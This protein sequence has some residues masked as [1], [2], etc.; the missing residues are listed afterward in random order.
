MA[1]DSCECGCEESLDLHDG[2]FC[3]ECGLELS[4]PGLDPGFLV[5]EPLVKRPGSSLG[6]KGPSPR[7]GSFFRVWPHRDSKGSRRSFIDDLAY[8]A[9]DSGE[10]PRIVADVVTLMRDVDERHPLGMRRRSLKGANGLDRGAARDYRLRLFVSAALHVLNDDGLENRAPMI[11]QEWGISYHDSVWAISI[12]NRHRRRGVRSGSDPSSIRRAELRFHLN[13]LREFVSTKVGFEE[14]EAIMLSAEARLSEG[15]E[16]IGRSDDWIIG[17]FCNVP[18]KRAAMI[19]FA[20]EMV[21]RGKPKKMVR[22]L[23]EQVPIIGT[24]DFVARIAVRGTEV[25]EE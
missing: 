8:K 22:W 14:A 1:F 20:E 25:G 18:S 3:V 6:G 19:S 4:G 24:K 2:V 13:R 12:F 15:G 16:P 10:C 5:P 11:A 7:D 17:R 9:M 21:S 23:R